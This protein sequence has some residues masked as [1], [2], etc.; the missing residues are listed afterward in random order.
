M[1][2]WKKYTL[3]TIAAALVA[4]LAGATSAVSSPR[5]E[6]GNIPGIS[7]G[8]DACRPDDVYNGLKQARPWGAPVNLA[9]RGITSRIPWRVEDNR[10][11]GTHGFT[12]VEAGA[13]K[14]H[15]GTDL[16]GEIGESVRAVVSGKVLVARSEPESDTIG[17][18]VILRASFIVPPAL[19]CAVDILYAHLQSVSVT[20]NQ[21][22]NEGAEIGKIGRTG[23]L[24]S[25]IPTHLHIELWTA[26]YRGGLLERI[27]LT[28]DIMEVFRASI[29]GLG[30]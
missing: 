3:V 30:R 8:T 6:Y 19:P 28:R 4:S 13:P 27:R 25:S 18:Y 10:E 21:Q 12:R 14:F 26:P 24:N 22:V 16:L 20:A 11:V 2:W 9:V 5:I 15:A 23:N 1:S 7:A 29:P 17:K